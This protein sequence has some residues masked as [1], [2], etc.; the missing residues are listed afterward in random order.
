MPETN[1]VLSTYFLKKESG[2]PDEFNKFLN[3]I[4]QSDHRLEHITIKCDA[5]SEYTYD[6]SLQRCR[7]PG[8][9]SICSPPHDPM[10][11]G[12]SEKTLRDIGDLAQTI[13][14]TSAFPSDGLT[15]AYHHATWLKDR[16]PTERLDGDTPYYKMFSKNYDMSSVCI[17]GFRAFAHI[18]EAQRT[19][20]EPR[21]AEGVYVGHNDVSSTHVVYFSST[22]RTCVVGTPTFIEDVDAYASR[23]TKSSFVTAN[24]VDH[25]EMF[26]DKPAPFHDIVDPEVSFDIIALGAWYSR[27][28]HK[29]ISLL[30]LRPACSGNHFP[31]V[32]RA[33]GAPVVTT[34]ST[35][36]HQ[37]PTVSTTGHQLPTVSLVPVEPGQQGHPADPSDYPAPDRDSFWTTLTRYVSGPSSVVPSRFK[38]VRTIITSWGHYGF[39]GG[40]HPA[41]IS[42]NT[43]TCRSG[44]V[45][46][47]SADCEA[48]ISAVDTSS[49]SANTDMYTVVHDPDKHLQPQDVP[50]S[51]VIFNTMHTTSTVNCSCSLQL[52]SAAVRYNQLQSAAVNC[53]QLQSAAVSCSCNEAT[54]RNHQADPPRAAAADPLSAAATDQQLQQQIHS[55]AT[56]YAQ[57]HQQL[58]HQPL[59]PTTPLRAHEATIHAEQQ[60]QHPPHGHLRADPLQQTHEA[61]FLKQVGREGYFTNR[62]F[63]LNNQYPRSKQ[64]AVEAQLYHAIDSATSLFRVILVHTDDNFGICSYDKFWT[65]FVANMQKCFDTDVKEKCTIMPQMSMERKDN[66][67]E[68]HQLRQ[69]EDIIDEFGEDTTLKAVDS[70]MIKGL[71]LPSNTI[72]DPNLRYR[73]LIG[74]LLGIARCTR[75]DI[76]FAIIYLSRFSNCAT[77]IHWD[78]LIRFVRYLKTTFK[79]PFVL[80]LSNDT[81]MDK[82]KI[83][84]TTDVDWA[85]DIVNKKS[86]SGSRVITD[87]ALINFITSKQP[88]STSSTEAEYI[89]ASNGCREGL[90]FRNLL[91]KLLTVITPSGALID[92]IGAGARTSPTSSQRRWPHLL[93]KL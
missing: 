32:S 41:L 38:A 40:F 49:A 44:G 42:S 17:F 72:A 47:A 22:N 11:N 30:Q 1:P 56:L 71:N 7:E 50:A 48:I 23:L 92:N 37:L 4:K 65:K 79:I 25:T 39:L 54:I 86:F 78:A 84:I 2:A 20:L 88:M 64:S 63:I 33:T 46:G 58:Q 51:R 8:I 34:V 28:D 69:I 29:L 26:Y 45:R 10:R 73:A 75:L 43:G 35:A 67:F 15:R 76:L 61:I 68:I 89:S 9:T 81:S 3:D 90:Y 31:T 5:E 87:G 77:K 13:M 60:M 24:P 14:A 19:N 12:S 91:S 93:T 83:T 70:P 62:E 57:Q 74:A 59:E 6:L 16:L 55:E 52:Q 80:K 85:H 53:S 66:P 21:A 18:P 82:A 27:E 36:G